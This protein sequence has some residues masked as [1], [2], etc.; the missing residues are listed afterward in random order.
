MSGNCD[1]TPSCTRGISLYSARGKKQKTE[2]TFL[3][4]TLGAQISDDFVG[5][6]VQL[7][8]VAALL[9]RHAVQREVINALQPRD[10][11]PAIIKNT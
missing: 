2:L 6:G 10:Q 4:A 11:L 8:E 5:A 3:V 1:E 9:R 7:D